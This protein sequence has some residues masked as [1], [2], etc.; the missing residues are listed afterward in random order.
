MSIG[1]EFGSDLAVVVQCQKQIILV[2][3]EVVQDDMKA[4]EFGFGIY[5]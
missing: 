5:V 4:L 1:L 2:S 3:V